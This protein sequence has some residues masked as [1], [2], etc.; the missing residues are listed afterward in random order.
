MEQNLSSNFKRGSEQGLVSVVVPIYNSQDFLRDCLMSILNQTYSNLEIILVNDGSSDESLSICTEYANRYANIKLVHQENRGVSAAMNAGIRCSTGKYIARV[1]SD[2]ICQ[3]DRIARQVE[4]LERNQSIAVVSSGYSMFSSQLNDGAV[5]QHPTNPNVILLSL[6]VCCP[7]AQPC[8]M[9][10]ADVFCDFCYDETLVVAEDHKLWCDIVR[11]YQMSNIL[12]PL[13]NYRIHDNSL[14]KR[15]LKLIRWYTFLNGCAH[16]LRMSRRISTCTF[17][18]IKQ[19]K[20]ESPQLKWGLITFCL[21][22]AKTINFIP[23][24]LTSRIDQA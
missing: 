1:D 19:A 13:I 12:Q 5:V 14:S 8:A 21:I 20:I 10:R 15:K 9:F 11:K 18:E 24:L 22:F 17:D 16:F 6:V 2:D 23:N 4:F 7:F 3:L